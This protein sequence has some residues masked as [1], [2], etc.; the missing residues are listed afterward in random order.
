MYRQEIVLIYTHPVK[1]WTQ[2]FSHF[3]H[4]IGIFISV[5][6]TIQ[7][8]TI[9]SIRHP[10]INHLYTI[11]IVGLIST[12]S[13]MVIGVIAGYT[14]YYRAVTDRKNLEYQQRRFE[15]SNRPQMPDSD[16]VEDSKMRRARE[17]R[18]QRQ[19]ENPTAN[20]GI[21]PDESK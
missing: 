21:P 3:S 8:V 19:S 13:G 11:D 5:F 10:S 18:E 1:S 2:S 9:L 20:P 6:L 15:A 4:R 14:A 16:E 7:G 12:V 17:R